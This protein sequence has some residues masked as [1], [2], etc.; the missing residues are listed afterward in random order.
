MPESQDQNQNQDPQSPDATSSG[1]GS[2]G[3]NQPTASDK[4]ATK[5]KPQDTPKPVE[6]PRRVRVTVAEGHTLGPLL[7]KNGDITSDA[8]YV[9]ILEVPGQTK[10]VEVK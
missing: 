5:T 2:A 4:T 10:V 9:G 1:A 8:D 3:G 7:L 6:K